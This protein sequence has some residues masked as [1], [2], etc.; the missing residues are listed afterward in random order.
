MNQFSS[1]THL[2]D[3]LS[4]SAS[5][6]QQ[7]DF[8]S[9]APAKYASSEVREFLRWWGNRFEQTYKYRYPFQKK[10]VVAA[11]QL[12]KHYRAEELKRIIEKAWSK[13]DANRYWHCVKRSS[14]L[15]KL[16]SSIADIVVELNQAQRSPLI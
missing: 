15:P 10:D 4:M 9:S 2:H 11:A 12:L 7:L 6:A 16:L 14:T 5:K 3:P 1:L 8:F 13:T